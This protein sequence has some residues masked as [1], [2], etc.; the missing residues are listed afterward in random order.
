MYPFSDNYSTNS[1]NNSK[2]LPLKFLFCQGKRRQE[3]SYVSAE[4]SF[5][6]KMVTSTNNVLLNGI[7]D[8]DYDLVTH[9]DAYVSYN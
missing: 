4:D 8:Y 1:I 2:E 7:D 5:S 6:N 3:H 9:T